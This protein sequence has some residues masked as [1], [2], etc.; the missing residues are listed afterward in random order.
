M[1]G[2]DNIPTGQF[3]GTDVYLYYWQAEIISEQGRL[4]SRDMYRWLPI[5]RDLGQTLNLYSYAVAYTHKCLMPFFPRLTLYDV[6]LVAPV[7]CFVLSLGVLCCYL[8]HV[9]GFTVSCIVGVL[10][11]TLPVTILRSLVGFS[12]RD[13][14]CL[15]LGV[16][17]VT[18][19]LWKFQTQRT[20]H[21]YFL[22]AISG[23][24]VFFG[25]LSWEG[26]G[27]FVLTILFTEI[28]QFLT[29]E[30][31]NSIGAYVIWISMFVPTLFLVSPAYRIGSGFSTHITALVLLPPLVLL[32]IRYLRHLLITVF[33]FSKR[34]RTYT[35][36]VA[37][38][39]I[40]VSLLIGLLYIF[41][42]RSS[43]EQTT[44]PF[45]DSHLMQTVSE[46]KDASYLYWILHFGG[47]FL[48]GNIGL[49]VIIIQRCEK[50]GN[51]LV[52]PVA[53]FILT[54]FFRK[55]LNGIFGEPLCDTFFLMS[56]L[57]IPGI[58]L[59]VAW[60]RKEPTKN[61]QSYVAII[62][63]FLI[64][65]GL[66]RGAERYSFFAALPLTFFTAVLVRLIVEKSV[67]NITIYT[68][69][70][71]RSPTPGSANGTSHLRDGTV[72]IAISLFLKI[73]IPVIILAGLLF[74]APMGKHASRIVEAAVHT[75]KP[76]PGHGAKKEALEWMKTEL[77]KKHAIVA[78]SWEYGSLLN[79]LGGVKTIIDQDHFIPYW[80]HLYCRHVFAGQ[81]S[82]ETLEFLRAH[83]VTHLMLMEDDLL[84]NAG[85]YAYVGS[86]D[87][88]DRFGN[89]VEMVPQPPVNI[90]YQM[91]PF[92]PNTSL[93]RIDINF[94]D[95][96]IHETL[97]VKALL[98]SEETLVDIPYIAF[99]DKERFEGGIE[100]A[101]SKSIGGIVIYFDTDKQIDSA[102]YATPTVWNNLTFKLFF[103]NMES[104][105]FIPVYPKKEFSTAKVKLWEVYYP[106]DVKPLLKY[107]TT[108]PQK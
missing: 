25:G 85:T 74:W 69:R 33:P 101:S 91:V 88:L 66:S 57:L 55:H 40:I 93:A 95:N 54:N 77:A 43:F 28:W 52:F 11:A 58:A 2:K 21:R 89:I 98:K 8:Y 49:L 1:L 12:D 100:N 38:L 105:Y 44:V 13:S 48:L 51:A 68:R 20:A 61:E 4:P 36:T 29:S 72:S 27:V 14:W 64:W 63:W 76:F 104:P 90:K 60:L 97:T 82:I 18:T 84:E 107:R 9:Y 23:G 81:S 31:E 24:F 102:Y 73:S 87:D 22:S 16:A 7:I 96:K 106:P 99:H 67:E 50:I 83:D 92:L 86:H 71:N 37:F 39:L 45:S 108:A 65:S 10:L 42:Q 26:F 62:V 46:L 56:L 34:I 30:E 15:L 79:V 75:R 103:R 19:Y 17:A 6:M 80:I 3:N 78:A 70:G 5:G 41:I 35:R 94:D 59:C 47:V 32:G 53:L